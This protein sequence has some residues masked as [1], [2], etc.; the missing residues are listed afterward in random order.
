MDPVPRPTTP[1]TVMYE[2]EGPNDLAKQL[3]LASSSRPGTGARPSTT[4]TL[5]LPP[6]PATYASPRDHVAA[7]VSSVGGGKIWTV[8]ADFDNDSMKGS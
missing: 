4:D 5:K 3:K 8:D 7:E 1:N 2:D 6:G